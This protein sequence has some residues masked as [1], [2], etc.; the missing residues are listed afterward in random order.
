MCGNGS[1][2]LQLKDCIDLDF[3]RTLAVSSSRQ[4]AVKSSLETDV[5]LH[6]GE[7]CKITVLKRRPV[8]RLRMHSTRRKAS[9]SCQSIQ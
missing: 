4:V 3:R 8:I 9:E 1:A 2:V 6:V 5:R 7:K